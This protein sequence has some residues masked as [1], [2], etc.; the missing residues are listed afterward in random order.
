MVIGG[1]DEYDLAIL[2][3]HCSPDGRVSRYLGETL[4]D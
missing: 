4:I 1:A 3:P 2:N